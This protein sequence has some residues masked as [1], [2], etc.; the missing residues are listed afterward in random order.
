MLASGARWS[1]A[2]Q[3]AVRTQLARITNSRLFAFAPL[4]RRFL[5]YIVA[6]ALA[7]R[8]CRIKGYT[9]G[10]EV[11]GRPTTFDPIAD[12]IVRIEAGRLRDK[13]AA[14]N[15]T[16]GKDDPI[17]IGLPKGTYAPSIE[18]I[19]SSGGQSAR[20]SAHDEVLRGLEWHWHY[21]EASCA[22]AQH[23]FQR[24]IEIAP[25]RAGAHYW[26][27]RSYLLNAGLL[28]DYM[29]MAEAGRRHAYRTIELD[30]RSAFAHTILGWSY[31]YGKPGNRD[32][33]EASKGCEM[34]PTSADAKVFLSLILSA[35]GHSAEALDSA[36]TAVRL[37]PNPSC[38]SFDALGIAHFEL[39]TYDQAIDAYRRGVALNPSYLHCQ[40]GLAASYGASGQTELAQAQGAAVKAAWPGI[41]VNPFPHYRQADRWLRAW[42][43]AGL[44]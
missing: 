19:S 36:E 43:T 37:Q 27:A 41:V 29:P 39:G 16:D 1:E 35:R 4:K 23:H 21:T 9:L 12:P 42:R 2:D 11:F 18:L 8:A 24:A 25:D 20:K 13:L 17:R 34:D 33:L 44:E 38:L 40:L 10:V 30:P 14:Y 15:E 28:A 5:E 6:E 3:A 22:E 32:I 31:L 26:L 7:G